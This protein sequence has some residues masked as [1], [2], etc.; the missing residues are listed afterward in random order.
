MEVKTTEEVTRTFCDVCKKDITN[1]TRL[2]AGT[3]KPDQQ[4]V[5][6]GGGEYLLDEGHSRTL[7]PDPAYPGDYKFFSRPVFSDPVFGPKVELNCADIA[8]LKFKYPELLTS[9]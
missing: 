9:G 6:C 4:W 8:L 5:T 1:G 2:G 3:D 7:I